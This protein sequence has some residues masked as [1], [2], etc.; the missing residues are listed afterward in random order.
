MRELICQ[1]CG[2]TFI[3]TN[4][5][6]KN[7]KYCCR[8]CADNAR[9]RGALSCKNFPQGMPY[10]T[11]KIEITKAIPIF[12]YLRPQVGAVYEAERYDCTGALGY[13]IE[14]NGKK[15]NIRQDECKEV[16]G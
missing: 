12:K 16:V 3:Q 4:H 13:V 5:N 7:Q 11:V 10:T 8:E 6:K 1:M 2:N 15:I 9:R 14:I